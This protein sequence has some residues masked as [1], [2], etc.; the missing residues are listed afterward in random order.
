MQGSRE[1]ADEEGTTNPQGAWIGAPEP[2][3]APYHPD[4]NRVALASGAVQQLGGGQPHNNMQ[5]YLTFNF[6]IALVGIFP[7]RS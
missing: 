4:T 3:D 6:I 1:A 7:S 2:A 5:P